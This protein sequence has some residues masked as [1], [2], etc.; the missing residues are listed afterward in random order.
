[1]STKIS[2]NICFSKE[3]FRRKCRNFP[4]PARCFYVLF[5]ADKGAAFSNKKAV[6]LVRAINL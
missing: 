3:F 2:E 5:D 4:I 6:I 1:M